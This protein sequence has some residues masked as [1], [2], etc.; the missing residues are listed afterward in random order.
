MKTQKI[1]YL[2]AIALV[3]LSCEKKSSN[4]YVILKG[5]IANSKSNLKVNFWTGTLNKEIKIHQDGS[6]TDTLD[7]DN[8]TYYILKN[9][10]YTALPIYFTKG[11]TIQFK[12]DGKDILKTIEFSGDHAGFNNYLAYKAKKEYDIIFLD[13]EKFTLNEED[14]EQFLRNLQN[15]LEKKLSKI[16]NLSPDI[17][18]RELRAIRM[19]RLYCKKMYIDTHSYYAKKPEYKPSDAFVRDIKEMSLNNSEDYFFSLAYK[20]MVYIDIHDKVENLYKKDSIPYFDAL[21]DVISKK[22]EDIKNE[23]LYTL[24][25]RRLLNAQNSIKTAERFFALSTNDYHK[26]K[27]KELYASL[28]SLEPGQPSPKFVNYINYSGGTTSLDDLKG[29]YVYIDIWATWCGPCIKQIPFLTEVEHAYRDKNIV[30]VSI[31]I[32][33]GNKAISF[34]SEAKQQEM[35][36]AEEKWKTMVAEKE[37]EGIQLLADKGWES[38]FVKSYKTNGIP[39]FILIDPKGNIVTPNAPRP[40]DKELITLL[41]SLEL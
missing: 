30:F 15:D 16:E 22:N 7:I 20:K 4:D 8:G 41:D 9:Y 37:M 25:H 21:L 29:K 38:E 27:I 33:E 36:I 24:I 39:K 18:K 2:F 3:M 40:S 17:E 26:E 11:S 13:K 14:F 35:E 10:G 34:D 12:A 19:T 6:F 28:K 31:S 1:L 32:D 23:E 5:V